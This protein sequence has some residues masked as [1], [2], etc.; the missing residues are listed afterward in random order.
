MHISVFPEINSAHKGL[1]TRGSSLWFAS[2]VC[3]SLRLRCSKTWST[4]GPFWPW[5]RFH[6]LNSM[7]IPIMKTRQSWHHIIWKI[8]IPIPEKTGLVVI[9]F[10]WKGP[11]MIQFETWTLKVLLKVAGP[12]ALTL[13]VWTSCKF[14]IIKHQDLGWGQPQWR[15]LS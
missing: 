10:Y 7:D 2:F 14:G 8:G 12:V 11:L 6:N 3:F 13:H 5:G 15:P 1:R 9:T 4:S